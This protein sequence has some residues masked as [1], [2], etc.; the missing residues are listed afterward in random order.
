M[1]DL[2]HIARELVRTGS[3]GLLIA[4]VALAVVED[5]CEGRDAIFKEREEDTGV[6]DAFDA[7][8]G[9]SFGFQTERQ[10]RILFDRTYGC[11]VYAVYVGGVSSDR[12][13]RWDRVES[14]PVERLFARMDALID[15]SDAP[16]WTYVQEERARLRACDGYYTYRPYR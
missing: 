4:K 8:H 11:G 1:M 7:S 16:S 6:Q 2:D 3:L 10:R 9:Y 5:I 14:D 13:Y 15:A 12:A